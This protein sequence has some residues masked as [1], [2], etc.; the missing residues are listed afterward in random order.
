MKGQGLRLVSL[1]LVVSLSFGCSPLMSSHFGIRPDEPGPGANACEEYKALA[2]YG[3]ELQEA[4]HSRATQNR[5]SIYVAGTIGLGVI[6]AT[7]GLAAA[8]AVGLGTLALLSVSGGFASGFFAVLDN[9]TLADI[10]TISANRIATSLTE[11]DGRL[12]LDQSKGGDRYSDQNACVLALQHLRTGLTDAKN[13]LERARTDSAVAA[14]MRAQ[15]QAQ[16]LNQVIGQVQA[17]AVTTTTRRAQ[18][19]SVTPADLA[20]GG[21]RDVTL[22]VANA[23]F[24][25]VGF[26][27]VKVVLGPRKYDVHWAPPD[28]DGHYQ[29]KF[30]APKSP[31]DPAS[32][33][34]SPVLV[35]GKGED[36]IESA[37]KVLLKYP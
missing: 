19:T 4:Y 18:I 25:S 1:I 9:A 13:N 33:E 34:Y 26:D 32:K 6:A 7:G 16:K 36:R 27:D 37:S 22:T 30:V 2:I 35:V 29:V 15:A 5:W 10:Y 11:A 14:V 12:Q 17:S 21:P 28:A 3:Q 20:A 24:R 31:P 8:S 23:N